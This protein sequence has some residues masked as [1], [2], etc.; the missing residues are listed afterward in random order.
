[1][2]KSLNNEYPAPS[3]NFQNQ[4]SGYLLRKFKNSNGW[5]KL[6]VVF[7]NFCLFFY[8]SFQVNKQFLEKIDLMPILRNFESIKSFHI[9]RTITLWQVYHLLG[10]RYVN[11]PKWIIYKKILSSSCNLKI[12]YISSELNLTIRLIGIT[13][14]KKKLFIFSYFSWTNCFFFYHYSSIIVSL[15]SLDGCK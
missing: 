6:W 13:Y 12:T 7:T 9:S 4:L 8:K 5:Q 14:E 1:M 15:A 11:R 10:I 3:Y 2:D